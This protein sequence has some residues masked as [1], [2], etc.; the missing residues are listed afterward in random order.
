MYKLIWYDPVVLTDIKQLG[1]PIKKT[2]GWIL[3]KINEINRKKNLPAQI[4]F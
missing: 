2:L 3:K 4:F 1:Q